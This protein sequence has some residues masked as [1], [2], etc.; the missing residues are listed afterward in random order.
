MIFLR[1]G[2]ESSVKAFIQYVDISIGSQFVI[3]YDS[4]N[5]MKAYPWA[6]CWLFLA[7][8]WMVS[9]T[10]CITVIPKY[11]IDVVLTIVRT[12][13]KSWWHHQLESFSVLLALC[14]GN[15]LVTGGF[16]SQRPVTRSFDIF[17][18]LHLNKWLSK[19]LR[20]W[21]S[22]MPLC[23]LWHHCNDCMESYM[24]AYP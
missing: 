22:Q 15:P 23:S 18:D 19:Q 8:K 6:F 21:W 2:G 16:P 13:L 9:L 12:I 3:F 24:K 11:F 14:E 1:Y 7:L 5:D 20:C 10:R 17:F 4:S